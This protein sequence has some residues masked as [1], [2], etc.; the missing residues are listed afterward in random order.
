MVPLA[1]ISGY[2]VERIKLAIFWNMLFL[3]ILF[4][5]TYFLCGTQNARMPCK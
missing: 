1:E 3:E 5:Y 4:G 2:N